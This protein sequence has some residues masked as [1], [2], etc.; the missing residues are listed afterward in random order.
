LLK[1][2]K[3]TAAKK[4]AE[5]NKEKTKKLLILQL[6]RI[7][8][9]NRQ[10]IDNT[11]DSIR[12]ITESWIK[13]ITKKVNEAVTS[14]HRDDQAVRINSLMDE[15]SSKDLCILNQKLKRLLEQES[16]INELI[17]KIN[18]K[19]EHSESEQKIIFI[20]LINSF[21]ESKVVENIV[22]MITMI[23]QM[24][25]CIEHL[26]IYS[27]ETHSSCIKE[28]MSRN[29]QMFNK[30]FVP[31]RSPSCLCLRLE[32]LSSE[33]EQCRMMESYQKDCQL[34]L[35]DFRANFTN[36]SKTHLDSIESMLE[37]L[38]ELKNQIT[39]IKTKFDEMT[40]TKVSDFIFSCLDKINCDSLFRATTELQLEILE[41]K[42]NF[43][44]LKQNFIKFFQFEKENI[45]RIIFR[46]NE[47]VN[48]GLKQSLETM[49]DSI[50]YH[51]LLRH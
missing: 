36:S 10:E 38:S 16:F 27:N 8:S 6:E 48:Y 11:N 33:E 50:K 39:E 42:G 26:K 20:L 30:H 7:L 17:Q 19:S 37:G 4:E 5:Q 24:C 12:L 2:S 51:Q 34:V 35:D 45:D 22:K 21:L 32:F 15:S 47:V 49:I 3:E 46:G 13:Q 25:E 14:H 23:H 44:T 1:Q 28:L 29:T 40:K 31:D 43:E 41:K 18:S 9:S